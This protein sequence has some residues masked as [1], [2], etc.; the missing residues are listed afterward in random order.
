MLFYDNEK[1]SSK[2]AEYRKDFQECKA[3]AGDLI[4]AL[5][6]AELRLQE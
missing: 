2:H 4:A 6:R 5:K 3:L 1:L